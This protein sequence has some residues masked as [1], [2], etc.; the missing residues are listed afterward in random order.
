MRDTNISD[1]VISKRSDGEILR[2]RL[3]NQPPDITD[4]SKVQSR[5]NLQQA[6]QDERPNELREIIANL[7]NV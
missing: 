6:V 3:K 7:Q 1:E 4:L 5:N 2:E